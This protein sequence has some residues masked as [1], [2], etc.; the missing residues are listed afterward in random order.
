VAAIVLHDATCAGPQGPLGIR[1]PGLTTAW[2]LGGALFKAAGRFDH[3]IGAKQWSEA[4]TAACAAGEGAGIDELQVW[5]HGKWGQVFLADDVFDVGSLA[6]DSP[7]A[8]RLDRL[9]DAMAGPH[10]LVWLRTCETFG[11]DAGLTFAERLAARLGCRVA[12]HTHIIGPLQSGLHALAPGQTAAWSA[13]EGLVEGTPA[14]PRR[15]A[16]S[17][18]RSPRTIS[19]LHS[20]LPAWAYD[21]PARP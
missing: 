7:L 14:M 21:P 19:C 4:L 17:M 18:P 20:R 8:P 16:W 11:G 1:L 6:P 15:A 12:G 9:R 10:A 13:A 3:V 2:R 5:C